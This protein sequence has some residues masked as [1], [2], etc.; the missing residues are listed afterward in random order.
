MSERSDQIR[1]ALESIGVDP[2]T[3]RTRRGQ[4]RRA[5]ECGGAN[6][7]CRRGGT[8]G[9]R[10]EAAAPGGRGTAGDSVMVFAFASCPVRYSS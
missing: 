4:R 5:G 10:F 3:S 8:R 6:S 9:E 2:V 7:L 1:K